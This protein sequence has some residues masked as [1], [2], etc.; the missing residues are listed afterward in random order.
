MYG[1]KTTKLMRLLK[2]NDFFLFKIQNLDD[3]RG[4]IVKRDADALDVIVAFD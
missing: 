4:S 3:A 2:P 1:I